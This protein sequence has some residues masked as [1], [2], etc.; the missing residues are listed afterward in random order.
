[1]FGNPLSHK[2]N[3]F[4]RG[5]IYKKLEKLES[6]RHYIILWWISDY[7]GLIENEK[8]DQV[9]KYKAERRRN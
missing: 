1:M 4:L 9:A 2:K 7:S 6:N 5:L 3:R 8:T